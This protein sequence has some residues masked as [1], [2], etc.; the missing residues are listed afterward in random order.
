MAQQS[1]M[2]DLRPPV[3]TG[4]ISNSTSSVPVP[5]HVTQAIRD[6]VPADGFTVLPKRRGERSIILDWGVRVTSTLEGKKYVCWICQGSLE[7]RRENKIIQLFG[8][9]SKATK[10]L[11]EKH[12][13]T[14]G[15]ITAE[16]TRKRDRAEELER[17]RCAIAD[18]ADSR[19]MTLLLET[20]RV[21]NNNL[22]FRIGEY[23]ESELLADL[24]VPDEFRATIN[25]HTVTRAI[26]ELYISARQAIRSHLERSRVNN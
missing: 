7:C 11:G 4:I 20:M 26:A 10:H 25:N 13:L 17:I 2:P 21:V 18:G 15:K 3:S 14:A 5:I 12:L 8:N 23:D 16:T 6:Y 19:R 1:P 9:T 24:V 22:P